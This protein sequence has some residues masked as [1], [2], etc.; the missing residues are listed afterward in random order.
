M[1]QTIINI[2]T[3]ACFAVA[4]CLSPSLT[5]EPASDSIFPESFILDTNLEY[6]KEMLSA[7]RTVVNKASYLLESYES[8]L[9]EPGK[10]YLSGHAIYSQYHETTD[11]AGKFPILGRFPSQH[12]SGTSADESILDMADVSLTYAANDWVSVFVHGIY[13]DLQFPTQE[14]AQIREA[15]ITFGNLA[16][17]PWYLSVGRMTANFG[18]Q[19]SYNPVTHSVNNHFFRID[20]DDAAVELGYIG[21]D[22][23]FAF[24]ALNGGRQLRVADNPNNS[25]GSNFAIST[26]YDTELAG[27]DVSVGGGYLYSSI[28]DSDSANHP[29]VAPDPLTTRE[30]NGLLNTWVEA[31]KG[32]Y[33]IMAEYTQTER[34]WPA[35]APAP[36][37]PTFRVSKGAAVQGLTLQ[38]AYDTEI[39][40]K[41]TRF[42]LVYGKGILGNDGDEWENLQQI[43]AGAEVYITDNFALSLEYVYNRSFIPLIKLD[44]TAI[45]DV[46]T[47]TF[48]ISG[49]LFF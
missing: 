8:G 17:S 40:S 2:R 3:L 38:A 42:S 6:S 29:G 32:P 25:F 23:R 48:I 24:T 44:R 12:S 18:H 10:I 5:A 21:E 22:W 30:R 15:F 13:T 9:L 33:S 39:L 49:T 43:A 26:Q 27:W 45:R 4:S 28:Y 34:D 37:P 7:Q 35:T 46:D 14:E 1:K 31:K 19:G 36:A 41:D 47:E 11:T 20:S 16:E